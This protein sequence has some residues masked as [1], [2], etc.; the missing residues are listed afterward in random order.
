MILNFPAR[1][2]AAVRD[3]IA[4]HHLHALVD[5]AIFIL[6]TLIFHKLWWSFY[7]WLSSFGLITASAD[8]L[9][10]NVYLISLWINTHI[11]GM[12][13][14]TTEPNTMWFAN[15]A[16]VSVDEGCSGLK[17][18]YQVAVLFIL[19]PGPWKHKLWYIP[20]GFLVMFLTNVFRIVVLSYTA[21]RA[22][23]YWDFTHE[24]ILRIFFYVVLFLLWVVWV[25]KFRRKNH[26][27]AFSGNKADQKK[28]L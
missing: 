27:P 26:K 1:I 5:V 22:P 7:G 23:E 16:Y 6:I 11:L 4:K 19:F 9:A 28:N 8:W 14:Y 15:G 24:W 25:E 10:R 2:F 3:F 18:M 13:V 12:D 20:S 21:L 17:Q